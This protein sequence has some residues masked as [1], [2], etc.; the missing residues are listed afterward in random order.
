[1]KAFKEIK[2]LYIILHTDKDE[3]RPSWVTERNYSNNMEIINDLENAMN[4]L[5]SKDKSNEASES[6]NKRH[7]SIWESLRSLRE[8]R[9]RE[10]MESPRFGRG[11]RHSSVT[12]KNSV[13]LPKDF[14]D[15][16][17]LAY[18]T[19]NIKKIFDKRKRYFSFNESSNNSLDSS[20]NNYISYENL[21][22]QKGKDY[23]PSFAPNYSMRAFGQHKTQKGP[24]K[25]QLKQIA[26]KVK[27]DNFSFRSGSKRGSDSQA[28]RIEMSFYKHR[29]KSKNS[30]GVNKKFRKY[31]DNQYKSEKPLKAYS[32]KK[33]AGNLSASSIDSSSSSGQETGKVK[34]K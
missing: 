3:T 25:N 33:Y 13:M 21:L 32:P 28:K 22:A 17:E 11:S 9:L 20:E 26:T 7:S 14:N 10:S 19:A 4:Q 18:T 15:E 29:R 5:L 23:T 24:F 34:L 6:P 16:L 12:K 2:T 30:L 1:M 8:K 27:E 31:S